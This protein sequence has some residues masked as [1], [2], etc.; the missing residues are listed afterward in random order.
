LQT[1]EM[2]RMRK[3]MIAGGVVAVMV[4]CSNCS[5]AAP[6]KPVAPIAPSA[7]VTV[8]ETPTEFGLSAKVGTLGVGA[9]LTVGL[10][11]RFNT[12][13]GFNMANFAISQSDSDDNSKKIKATIDFMTVP[14]LLDCH[15]FKG[16]FRLTGGLCVNKNEVKLSSNKDDTV[17]V[18]DT[19]YAVNSLEGDVSFSTLA[20]YLGIGFGNAVG[21]DGNWHFAMDIGVMFQGAPQI[22]LSAVASNPDLQAALDRDIEEEIQKREDDWKAFNMFPVISIGV[23]YNF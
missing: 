17:D 4:V 10:S 2:L 18:N 15:P 13:V 11:R 1:Q 16:C 5:L 23:S 9:D 7:P 20:P 8:A 19:E 21:S 12:R 14:L 6:P 22:D 3:E